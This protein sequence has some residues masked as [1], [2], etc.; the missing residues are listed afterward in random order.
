[1]GRFNVNQEMGFLIVFVILISGSSP[2]V[3][4]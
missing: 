4:G 1:M 2:V 3:R